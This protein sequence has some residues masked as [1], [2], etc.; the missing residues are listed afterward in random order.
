MIPWRQDTNKNSPWPVHP[1]RHTQAVDP[2]A[3]TPKLTGRHTCTESQTHWVSHTVIMEGHV[4]SHGRIV[5]ASLPCS[6]HVQTCS[7]VVRFRLTAA[8]EQPTLSQDARVPGCTCHVRQGCQRSAPYTTGGG[9]A[10]GTHDPFSWKTSWKTCVALRRM[11]VCGGLVLGPCSRKELPKMI[12]QTF[13]ELMGSPVL[14][15]PRRLYGK[16]IWSCRG[17]AQG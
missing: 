7:Y 2:C 6:E 1:F 14:G 3:P 11:W 13:P 4:E 16:G 10:R 17:G 15:G 9:Q 8:T 12:L 5:T